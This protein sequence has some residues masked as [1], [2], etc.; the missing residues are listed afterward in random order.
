MLAVVVEAEAA[1]D[2]AHHARAVGRLAG[3]QR[4][5]AGRAG[6]RGAKGLA[7]D[8]ALIRNPLEVGRGDGVSIGL[9]VA[10]GV[11]RVDV[12]DVGVGHG[13]SP[14]GTIK[15]ASSCGTTNAK[16]TKRATL[17]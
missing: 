10:T 5:A 2:E 9:D 11:V 17:C 12:D 13:G 1:V 6:G 16:K 4:G 15:F 3:K 14:S 8:H 7:E